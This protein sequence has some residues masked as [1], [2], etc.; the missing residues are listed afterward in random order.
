MR[1]LNGE[2]ESIRRLLFGDQGSFDEGLPSFHETGVRYGLPNWNTERMQ[3][4]ETGEFYNTTPEKYCWTYYAE[5]ESDW[6]D[7][8]ETEEGRVWKEEIIPNFEQNHSSVPVILT[9]DV[10][11][12]YFFNS[13][14]ASILDGAFFT[15]A[16]YRDGNAVCLVSAA[17]ARQNRLSVGDTMKMDFFH[18]QY[19]MTMYTILQGSGRSG[20]AGGQSCFPCRYGFCAEGI[21]P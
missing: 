5:Y 20:M 3:N 1:A 15:D 9:D 17:Y 2:F 14:D 19:E 12:M 7:F 18:N 16:D 13:G 8:L 4:P 11:S 6:R 10:K 21:R